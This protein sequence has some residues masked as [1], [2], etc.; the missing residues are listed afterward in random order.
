MTTKVIDMNWPDK[1]FS[2]N[3]LVGLA[4]VMD[5]DLMACLG[6]RHI[7]ASEELNIF[8]V[9]T[10]DKAVLIPEFLTAHSP[11]LIVMELC[12]QEESVLNGLESINYCRKQWPLVPIIVCTALTK[13]E[14]LHQIKCLGVASICC[15]NDSLHS[16]KRSLI[17]SLCGSYQDSP[18]ATQ[19]LQAYTGN[20]PVLTSKEIKVLSYLLDGSS[21]TATAQ[22][23][24]RSVK[25]ISS[26]KRN[27]MT[28]LGFKNDSQLYLQGLRMS[29][30]SLLTQ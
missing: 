14:F 20:M 26:H 3:S 5:P 15:K 11:T 17:F 2:F 29:R 27:A 10:L 16:L 18:T 25:T 7:L 19:Q 24:H 28:K 9:M 13:M 30:N 22:K 4:L 23:L 21:V 8:N 6:L 1:T 12:G